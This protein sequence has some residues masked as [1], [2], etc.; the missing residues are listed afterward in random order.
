VGLIQPVEGLD[1][2]DRFTEEEAILL[3]DGNIRK[4]ATCS[5]KFRL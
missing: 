1:S 3:Q 2:K 4:L 5:A